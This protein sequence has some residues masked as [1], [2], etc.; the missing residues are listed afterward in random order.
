MSG[1]F[2]GL[3]LV[4]GAVFALITVFCG[5]VHLALAFAWVKW[6]DVTPELHY[7]VCLLF[8]F[9]VFL[10]GRYDGL[11]EGAT[12]VANYVALFGLGS[13]VVLLTLAGVFSA[14]RRIRRGRRS[15]AML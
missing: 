2:T 5:V 15:G 9:V 14:G 6:R 7:P 13:E 1:L 12:A 11:P 4:C 8:A 10:F 3:V